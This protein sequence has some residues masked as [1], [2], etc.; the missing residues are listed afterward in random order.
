MMPFSDILVPIDYS[1]AG[2]AALRVAAQLARAARGRLL[3]THMLPP[4]YT[5]AEFPILPID[6]EWIAEER[7]RLD[8]HVR[9]ALAPTDGELPSFAVEVFV[10]TPFLGIV[11]LAAERKVDLIVIGTHGRSGLKRLVLGS[12]AERVVRFA[13]CPVLTVHGPVATR[14]P[15]AARG[16]VGARTGAAE[17]AA[18]RQPIVTRPG[19]VGQLM[20]RSPI[21]VEANTTLAEA[22][23]LMA[24]YRVR[25][26]PVVDRSK[27]V[28]IL[29]DADLG[30]YVGYLGNTKVNAAMTP[31][32]IAIAPDADA[33]VAAS[34]MLEHKV[35]ALPVTEGE[36]VVGVISVSDVLEDY[37]KAARR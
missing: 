32:P 34:L 15:V 28:G 11:R 13:P 23:G 22:R 31:N 7:S 27:L 2:D 19:E 14:G 6:A 8:A 10:D 33:A 1:E 5:M 26:L 29:S 25:H 36:T 20:Y 21:T 16:H 17:P 9:E 30:P 24:T 18:V 35:R 4:V 3:V 37:V 12:V